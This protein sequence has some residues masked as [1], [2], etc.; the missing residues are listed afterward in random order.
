MLAFRQQ[1]VR[2]LVLA[3]TAMIYT[4][5]SLALFSLLLPF[6]GLS[7]TTVVIGLVLYSLTILV[8]NMLAGLAGVATRWWTPPCGMGYSAIGC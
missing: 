2:G 5:P 8:R 3:G 7:P 6:T 1:R 4:V